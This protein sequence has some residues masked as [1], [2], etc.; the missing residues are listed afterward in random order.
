MSLACSCLTQE[1]KFAVCLGACS[2][3]G[4]PGHHVALIVLDERGVGGCAA[5]VFSDTSTCGDLGLAVV[6]PI[7]VGKSCAWASRNRP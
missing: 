7:T 1:E 5:T 2:H 6:M 4:Q 3:L